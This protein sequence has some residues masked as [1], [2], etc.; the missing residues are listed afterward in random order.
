MD[1]AV[2]S[3]FQGGFLCVEERSWAAQFGQLHAWQ[4]KRSHLRG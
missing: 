4:Y 2:L 3:V 1:E